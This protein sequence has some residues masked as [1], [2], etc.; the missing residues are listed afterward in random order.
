MDDEKNIVRVFVCIGGMCFCSILKYH[1]LIYNFYNIVS[2]LLK[3]ILLISLFKLH[4]IAV[5]IIDYKV[6]AGKTDPHKL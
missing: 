4:N 6:I 5:Y 2:R 1:V 3:V